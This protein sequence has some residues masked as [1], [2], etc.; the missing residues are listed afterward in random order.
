MPGVR[1]T[2]PDYDAYSPKWKRCRDVIAGQD[3]VQKAGPAYLPRLKDE[4]DC[5]YQARVKRSDFFNGTARTIDALVGMAFRKP[6]TDDVPASLKPYLEDVT[7]SGVTMESLAKKTTAEVLG[8]GRVGILIDHPPQKTDDNG[9]VLPLTMQAAQAMGQRPTLQLYT[10]ESIRNWKFTRIDNAWVLSL[11]VLGEKAAVPKD[12]FEDSIEDH[13]RV[14]DL[15]DGGFYRQRVFRI[16]KEQDV[17]ISEFTPLMNG[18][19]LNYIPFVIIGPGGK[20]DEI[21]VPPL[22]DLVDKNIAHYQVNSDYRHGL[23]FT[24]LPTPY[25]AGWSPPTG[26]DGKVEKLYIGSPAAWIFT[27]PNAK[28]EFLE[29]KGEGLKSI[30]DALTRIETQMALLGARMIADETKQVETLGAQLIKRQGEISILSKTVQSISEALEWALGVFAEWAGQ[31]AKIKYQLN[32]DFVPAMMDG[33]EIMGIVQAFQAGAISEPEM[34]E[35]FQRA[36]VIDGSK[37]LEAHQEEIRS[38]PA[39]GPAR[40]ATAGSATGATA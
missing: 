36:D 4:E 28:A 12:E 15:A 31:K 19:P 25:V 33:R 9:K 18:K 29:F 37:T 14:L 39:Q 27:E 8:P 23:H 17:L 5:D 34:F 7:L 11:V 13:Y 32:R 22:L 21:D 26:A 6:P 24:G 20:G 40:P 38:N 1:S 10:A 16:E 35:L 30:A 3:A 2:H